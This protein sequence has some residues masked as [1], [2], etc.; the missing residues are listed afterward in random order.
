MLLVGINYN[1]DGTRYIAAMIY[2]VD[3]TEKECDE[4]I[5][6]ISTNYDEFYIYDNFNPNY[7]PLIEEIVLKG[8]RL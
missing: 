7:A 8:C 5:A 6:L 1:T 3:M 4:S 2:R